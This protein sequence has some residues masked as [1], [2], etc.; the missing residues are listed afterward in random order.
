MTPE[1]NNNEVTISVERFQQ[2]IRAENDA[3]CLKKLIAEKYENYDTFDR[4]TMELLYT[5][6]VGKK[7]KSEL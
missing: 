6:Y 4:A 1:K 7:E 3:N 2:L 5:I